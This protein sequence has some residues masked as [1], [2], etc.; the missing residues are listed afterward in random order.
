MA[1]IS[2]ITD[3]RLLAQLFTEGR[4]SAVLRLDSHEAQ[5]I[6]ELAR[7]LF[8]LVNWATLPAGMMR[9]S[10]GSSTAISR[11]ATRQI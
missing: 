4:V 3:R 9:Q 6:E 7:I 10:N 5:A 11:S 8:Y 1:H 2:G